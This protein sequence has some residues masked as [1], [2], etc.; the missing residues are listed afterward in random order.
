VVVGAS[1]NRVMFTWALALRGCSVD[2]FERDR[3]MG[4]TPSA[5]TEWL[6]P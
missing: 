3:L 6:K 2:L 1:I 4:S 5:F